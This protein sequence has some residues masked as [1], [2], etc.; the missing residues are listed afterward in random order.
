MNE[1]EGR[2]A[3]KKF[4]PIDAYDPLIDTEDPVQIIHDY[5]DHLTRK[6]FA[7]SRWFYANGE[8]ELKQCEVLRYLQEEELYEVK[9][10]SNDTTKKV[11]RFN[12]IF[13]NEDEEAFKRRIEEA[14]RH[15]QDAELIMKYYYMIDNTKT[16]KFEISDDE[17]TRIS[18]YISSFK[19]N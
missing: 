8:S 9:W 5:R 17:K 6:T 3:R 18:Y 2:I 10:L 13:L 15:R 19:S 12:L 7:K 14:R 16:P 11:S 1:E 4:L